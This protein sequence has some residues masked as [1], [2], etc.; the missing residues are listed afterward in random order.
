M[1]G[2]RHYRAFS[3]SSA[4]VFPGQVQD[5]TQRKRP[6]ASTRVTNPAREVTGARTATFGTN[7][8]LRTE[9][10]P[11]M[12][13]VT[14]D[15][16]AEMITNEITMPSIKHMSADPLRAPGVAVLPGPKRSR[17]AGRRSDR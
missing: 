13:A 7:H 14:T 10:E 1:P 9:D 16:M 3:V 5:V 8:Q 15:E 4:G 12:M 2:K 11:T 6:A 17:P